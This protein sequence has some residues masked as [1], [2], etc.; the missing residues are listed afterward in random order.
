MQC[1]NATAIRME[2]TK[3]FDIR[4][5]EHIYEKYFIVALQKVLQASEMP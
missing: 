1:N 4:A 2:Y 5:C 3:V